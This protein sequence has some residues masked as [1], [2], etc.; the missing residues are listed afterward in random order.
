MF[1]LHP[2]Q[3]DAPLIPGTDQMDGYSCRFQ[4]V[5]GPPLSKC[6]EHRTRWVVDGGG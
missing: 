2:G 3:G 5:R 1:G 6:G 4:T